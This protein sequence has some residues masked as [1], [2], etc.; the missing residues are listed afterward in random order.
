MSGSH[1]YCFKI[2][3]LIYLFDTSYLLFGC[4]L[5]T[6]P[7]PEKRKQEMFQR[8]LVSASRTFQNSLFCV[9]DGDGL[10]ITGPV[11]VNLKPK[12]IFLLVWSTSFAVIFLSLLH[13]PLYIFLSWV[14]S[15]SFPY[16]SNVFSLS[17]PAYPNAHP[18]TPTHTYSG[19]KVR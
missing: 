17:P 12:H 9:N 15:I 3:L 8:H 5:N 7:T 10:N 18:H 11:W 4:I 13:I 19:S 14:G 16:N 6:L 2:D 1:L